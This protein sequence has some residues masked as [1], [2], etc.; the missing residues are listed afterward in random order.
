MLTVW[1]KSL[2]GGRMATTRLL[3]VAIAAV[4]LAFAVSQFRFYLATARTPESQVPGENERERRFN[5]RQA[6]RRLQISALSAIAGGCMLAGML[7][8]CGDHPRVFAL[9]W[10]G[11]MLFGV[12]VVALA[13]VDCVSTWMHFAEERQVH[14]AERL[15]LR[16]KMDKFQEDALRARRESEQSEDDTGTNREN[17]EKE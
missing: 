2:D 7:V 17:K 8:P 11:V 6:W 4:V 16:Y 9:S 3:G 12:W 14:E 15:A 13:L 1:A 10:F 5:R